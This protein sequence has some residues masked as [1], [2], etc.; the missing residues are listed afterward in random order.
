MY[1]MR[2]CL[3]ELCVERHNLFLTSNEFRFSVSK[4]V[5]QVFGHHQLVCTML[6]SSTLWSFTGRPS[7]ALIH[8]TFLHLSYISDPT[9][10]YFLNWTFVVVIFYI[11]FVFFSSEFKSFLTIRLTYL[12]TLFS[13]A[14]FPSFCCTFI[15]TTDLNIIYLSL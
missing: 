5:F 11:H 2:D 14:I 15:L 9:F 12:W 7:S 1:T 3:Q 10:Y 6:P 8:P 4:L 13:S